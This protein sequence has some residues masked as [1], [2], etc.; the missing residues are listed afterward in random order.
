M[1][2]SATGTFPGG[3]FGFGFWG[4]FVVSGTAKVNPASLKAPCV[5]IFPGSTSFTGFDSGIPAA[6]GH[7]N[8]GSFSG[9]VG[10]CQSQVVQVTW[11][12]EGSWN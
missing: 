12:W 10:E 6:A 4:T 5:A 3:G 7:C 2:P 11:T 9:A 8:F 1:I